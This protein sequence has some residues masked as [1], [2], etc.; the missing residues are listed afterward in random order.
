MPHESPWVVTVP[1]IALAIPSV[2]IG[3]LTV[4]SVLFGDYFGKA[5]FVLPAND[6]VGEGGRGVRRLGVDFALHG[7][8]S[9]AVLAGA[10]RGG[11]PPGCSS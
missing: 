6:V 2:V 8:R 10:R 11:R 9:T 3:A 7:F 5:I 1:L 4:E